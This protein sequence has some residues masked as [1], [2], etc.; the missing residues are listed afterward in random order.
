MLSPKFW[1]FVAQK[2]RPF[3]D[4]DMNGKKISGLPT[5]DYPTLDSEAPTKKYVDDLL[6][7]DE[8]VLLDPGIMDSAWDGDGR[9]DGHDDID[10]QTFGSGLPAGIKAVFVA[11]RCNDS[12]SS[13]GQCYFVIG[14]AGRWLSL[15]THTYH[16][17]MTDL[18]GRPNNETNYNAGLVVCNYGDIRYRIDA[19]G[20][21]TMDCWIVIFG[22]ILGD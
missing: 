3:F 10:L 22:Y 2:V 15:N 19:R 17:L 5:S 12:S 20:A 14:P 4:V 11:T 7:E 8:V 6:S 21:G 13:A 18:T 9:S 1:S 16:C